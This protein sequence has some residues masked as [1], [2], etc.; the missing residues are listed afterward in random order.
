MRQGGPDSEFSKSRTF[1]F[2]TTRLPQ[3]RMSRIFVI[4]LCKFLCRSLKELEKQIKEE[5]QMTVLHLIHIE[6]LT[7]FLAKH[8]EMLKQK[9]HIYMLGS[10]RINMC[11]I[12]PKNI[13]Y[14]ANAFHDVVSNTDTK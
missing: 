11:G 7:I 2:I 5:E 3:L 12:N 9:Y 10:G 1:K 4:N 6:F 13:D 14:I 8:V